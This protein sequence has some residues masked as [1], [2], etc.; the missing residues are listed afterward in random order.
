MPKTKRVSKEKRA[1]TA[2]AAEPVPK[3]VT[4][5]PDEL[6]YYLEMYEPTSEALEHIDVTRDEYITLKTHLA[7]LRGYV[8]EVAHA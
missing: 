6:D 2:P 4:E 3:W 7:K 8:V 1:K 5:T